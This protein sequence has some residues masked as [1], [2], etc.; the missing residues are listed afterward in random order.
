MANDCFDVSQNTLF[1]STLVT[2][3]NNQTGATYT[4]ALTDANSVVRFTT[5]GAKTLTV[6]TNATVALPI[7]AMIEVYAADAGATITIAPAGGVTIQSPFNYLAIPSGGGKGILR[8]VATNTWQFFMG[9]GVIERGASANGEWVKLADGTMIQKVAAIF[10]Q[11]TNAVGGNLFFNSAAANTWTYPQPFI[12]EPSV[13]AYIN[14]ASTRFAYAHTPA[15][16]SCG[17]QS[18]AGVSSA[19][20]IPVG[21]SAIGR[22]I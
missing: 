20:L 1:A 3:I 2:G 4:L 6:P 21:A 7:G 10:N 8:K 17:I 22:W 13:S 14:N 5:T 12:A 18:A 19:G 9:S 11:N 16:T 15:L